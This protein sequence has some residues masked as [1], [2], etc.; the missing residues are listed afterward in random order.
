MAAA[1]GMAFVNANLAAA[2][3]GIAAL[4]V[5]GAFLFTNAALI[6]FIAVPATGPYTRRR[7]SRQTLDSEASGPSQPQK[8]GEPS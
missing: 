5:V 8:Q 2:G 4:G 3:A 7:A 6:N 1:I